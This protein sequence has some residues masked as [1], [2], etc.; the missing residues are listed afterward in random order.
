[1]HVGVERERF[2]VAKPFGTS[3]RDEHQ[4]PARCV[5]ARE[6]L[7]E[8]LRAATPAVQYVQHDGLAVEAEQRKVLVAERLQSRTHRVD[9]GTCL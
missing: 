4:V 8:A 3:M 1:M 7:D 2:A 9:S 6:I 5:A